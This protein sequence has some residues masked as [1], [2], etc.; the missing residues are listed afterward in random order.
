MLY[1]RVKNTITCVT[2]MFFAALPLLWRQAN[3]SEETLQY[4]PF[5]TLTLYHNTAHPSHVAMFISGDGGWNLG[6]V[7]MA[8]A[9]AAQDALVVGFNIRHYIKKLDESKS[10]CVYPAADFERLSQPDYQQLLQNARLRHPATRFIVMLH[11]RSQQIVYMEQVDIVYK[12]L[13]MDEISRKI[14]YAIH[15]KQLRHAEEEL[16][17]MK[18]E[19]LRMFLG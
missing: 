10:A 12:P 3:A 17:R 8:R 13:T 9:L 11:Q 4:E 15:Q 16:K 19:V 1:G 14:R 18:K 5:G 6:V 2:L 7:D